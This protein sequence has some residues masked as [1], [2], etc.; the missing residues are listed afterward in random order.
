[1]QPKGRQPKSA[2]F[3]AAQL[4]RNGAASR[5]KRSN[6]EVP[7]PAPFI[8]LL[9]ENNSLL[10]A[11][12]FPVIFLSACGCAQRLLSPNDMKTNGFSEDGLTGGPA[13]EQGEKDFRAESVHVVSR[14]GISAGSY[15]QASK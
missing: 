6:R 2:T 15:P 9:S 4:R 14:V 13:P 11:N 3:R 1:M 12:N 10:I 7:V 8:S 5:L